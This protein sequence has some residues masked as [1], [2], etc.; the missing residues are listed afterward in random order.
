MDINIW[1]LYKVPY[2][3]FSFG[4]TYLSKTKQ[5]FAVPPY[6]TV[7]MSSNKDMLDYAFERNS[8]G[9]IANHIQGFVLGEGLVSRWRGGDS[10]M[11]ITA[12]DGKP[13]LGITDNGD[14]L[15]SIT[16]SNVA[17]RLIHA[18]S[19]SWNYLE[20][21]NWC[22]NTEIHYRNTDIHESDFTYD[23]K[24]VYFKQ[25]VILEV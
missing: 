2:R 1:Y 18:K 13:I 8:M 7:V 19:P 14:G 23:D 20:W 15:S 10:G 9:F 4:G 17:N 5:T 6:E 12:I 25:H 11:C 22:I 16:E 21:L 3:G 24:C